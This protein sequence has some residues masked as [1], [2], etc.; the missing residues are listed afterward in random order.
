MHHPVV[1]D[2][3]ELGPG[4]QVT[5]HG[6]QTGPAEAWEGFAGL[7]AADVPEQV[8]DMFRVVLVLVTAEHHV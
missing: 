7:D 5:D 1:V 8:P 6:L 4:L 2:G 3:L